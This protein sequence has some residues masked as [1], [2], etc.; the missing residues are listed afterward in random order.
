MGSTV[1][2]VEVD[3]FDGC[4]GRTKN[5]VLAAFSAVLLDL[6]TNRAIK[7]YK[8]FMIDGEKCDLMSTKDFHSDEMFNVDV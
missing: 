6:V 2:K 5:T 8:V 7:D 4:E 1:I 3:D